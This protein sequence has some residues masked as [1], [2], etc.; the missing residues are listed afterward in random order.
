[1]LSTAGGT[2]FDHHCRILETCN[3]LNFDRFKYLKF[4][5]AVYKIL[6]GLAMDFTKLKCATNRATRSIVRGDCDV[7]YRWT[8][9]RKSVLS[10]RGGNI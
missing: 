5:F 4:A 9:L 6:H 10:V 2:Y 1:M 3:L 7:P 8:N